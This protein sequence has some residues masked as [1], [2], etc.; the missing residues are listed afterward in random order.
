MT[1]SKMHRRKAEL[2]LELQK[3]EKLAKLAAPASLPDQ[4]KPTSAKEAEKAKRDLMNRIR[5]KK[6]GF[7]V[8][9]PVKTQMPQVVKNQS[10]DLVENDSD[11]EDKCKIISYFLQLLSSEIYIKIYLVNF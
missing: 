11:E 5:S 6:K 9:G 3:L 1:R 8:T 4:L 10:S 2:T 7:G